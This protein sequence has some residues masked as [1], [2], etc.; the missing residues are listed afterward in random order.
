MEIA[1][2]RNNDISVLHLEGELDLAVADE[3]EQRLLRAVQRADDR[4]DVD[5]SDVTYID[6][7]SV[8]ALLRAAEAAKDGGK[9]VQITS[10]SVIS[11]RVLELTGVGE[12]LG[13]AP[14]A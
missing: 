14:P 12:V 11:R 9:R 5:L 2:R 1:D 10:A 8:R 6:S 4:L 13:L 3:L 7:T